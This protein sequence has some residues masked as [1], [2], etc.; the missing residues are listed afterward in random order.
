[1]SEEQFWLY[2]QRGKA[3]DNRLIDYANNLLCK[4]P[5]QS[6]ISTVLTFLAF[7]LK[8]FEI[9][10]LSNPNEAKFY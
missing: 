6:S 3:I 4:L 7:K 9:F 2:K 5:F 10:D 1:M 8:F